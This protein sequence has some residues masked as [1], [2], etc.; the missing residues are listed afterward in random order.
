MWLIIC[1]Q[2]FGSI[3]KMNLS[4]SR[5]PSNSM[6]ERNSRNA[7]NTIG[8]PATSAIAE[9]LATGNPQEPKGRQQQQECLPLSGCKQQQWHKQQ[10][11]RQQ[12]AT[13]RMTA[14]SWQL[15]I[16]GTQA[17]V[18]LYSKQQQDHQ[19]R[20]DTI[21]SRDACKN[22]EASNSMKGGQWQQRH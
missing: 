4:N 1:I 22:S 2:Y 16:A 12:Q 11:Q 21:K 9:R 17:A 6:F 20:M 19:H 3:N 7:N 5:T 13:L 8:S 14:I 10:Q 15:T 18:G